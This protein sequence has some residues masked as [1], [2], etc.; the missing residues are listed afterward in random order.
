MTIKIYNTLTKRKEAF[1]PLQAGTIK[2]YVC[3]MTVY[4]LCHIGHARV[5][6]AFDT[7]VRYLRARGQKVTYV[8]NI[9][10]I[11]DKI[12]QRA[13]QNNESPKALAARFIQHMHEDE[14]RLSIV[15]PDMEPRATDYIAQMISMIGVLIE[16]NYAY[17]AVNGDIYYD[18]SKFKPYG[19]LSNKCTDALLAGA[20]V[21]INEAKRDPRDFVLWKAATSEEPHWDSPWGKG[22]PGWHIECSAMSVACLGET[23][24]I[25]G[26]GPDLCFPHHENEIAQSEAATGQS[27]VRYWMHV[28]AVRV[29]GE[30]MSKS[31][32]N[33]FTI[34]EVLKQH[35]PDVLR[36]LLI[37]SHY[38]SAIQYDDESLVQAKQVLTRF[39]MALEHYDNTPILPLVHWEKTSLHVQ[40]FVKALDDDFNTPEAIAIMF[41]VLKV[42]NIASQAQQTEQAMAL[43]QQLKL[44]GQLL[45][46]FHGPAVAFL[47]HASHQATAEWSADVID[48]KINDRLEAK[49]NKDY[50]LA[51]QIREEL[52]QQGIILE[53]SD[54]SCRWRRH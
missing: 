9:T 50:A 8:R 11:D 4:D 19:K 14:R 53:D 28:G 25:H 40:N 47:R 26:G 5:L 20:R 32:G 13:Q 16:K 2:L 21:S 38:R 37:S 35:H 36:Y 18:V 41:E 29:A 6:I 48:K 52:T 44:M 46:L 42:L 34:R 24:D 43:A 17:Q 49:H 33:F 54:G 30:K 22:R 51:D 15:S 10:D 27:F 45:G 31:L 3:G 23:F 39:Y 12:I 1:V 7:V